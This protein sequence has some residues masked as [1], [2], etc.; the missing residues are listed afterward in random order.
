MDTN[1]RKLIALLRNHKL[2]KDEMAE[3]FNT[4]PE[5]IEI[6]ID[7]LQAEGIP[8]NISNG[9]NSPDLTYHINVLPDIGNVFEVSGPT[10]ERKETLEGYSSDF[11]FASTFHLAPVWHDAMARTVDAGITR[12]YVAGDLMDGRNIYRGHLENILTA[13][14]EG[15]TDMVAEAM[16][17]YPELEFWGIA[18]NHDYSFTQLNGAKPLAI[19]EAKTDNFKNLGDLRADVIVDGIRIRL[20]HGGGGRAYATSYPS[21]TYLRDYFKGLEREELPNVPHVMLI[22]HFHTVYNS[23][24]H[25]IHILQPGSFQD[26][27]NEYCVRRGLTGP[28]GMFHIGMGFQNGVID[29]FTTTYVQPPSVKQEKGK[30]FASTT[31]QYHKRK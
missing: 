28:N 17:Q 15:Q 4:S 2:T 23:K 3:E 18:G 13:S 30:Q 19:L 6:W 1:E 26:S 22:G 25:G 16:S 9:H 7:T 11:H 12:V 27:D 20:L 24:D 31:K 14:I 10:D 8:V 29:E 21:Q 5:D